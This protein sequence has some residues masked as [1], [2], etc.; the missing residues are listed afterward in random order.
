M[1]TAP[2]TTPRQAPDFHDHS[3]AQTANGTL[4]NALIML[5]WTRCAQ[6]KPPN[7]N[8]A[9]P[10]SAPAGPTCRRSQPNVPAPA[11]Q[12]ENTVSK[13]NAFQVSIQG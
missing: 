13:L 8:S 4:A 10:V 12:I 11:S 3:S 9:A 2:S 1:A 5:V 6:V 7:P